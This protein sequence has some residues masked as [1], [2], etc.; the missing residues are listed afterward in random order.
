L[1][2]EKPRGDNAAMD[3]SHA[4]FK[5]TLLAALG[6]A[7]ALT[8]PAAAAPPGAKHADPETAAVGTRF[9]LEPHM[10][11]TRP[12]DLRPPTSTEWAATASLVISAPAREVATLQPNAGRGGFEPFTAPS[13]NTH[14]TRIPGNL[15]MFAQRVRHEGLPVARLWENHAALVSLGLNARGKPGIWLVQKTH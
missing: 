13:S 2:L 11:P 1:E 15:E 14:S 10:T 3:R 4:F 5:S 7:M 6:C 12:L 9:A 8:R